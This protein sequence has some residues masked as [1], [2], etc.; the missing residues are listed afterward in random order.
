M[1][2]CLFSTNFVTKC[3][4]HYNCDV[5]VNV[6]KVVE[7]MHKFNK[8]I[9]FSKSVVFSGIKKFL[10]RSLRDKNAEIYLT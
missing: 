5:S 3:V 8:S 7:K 2:F 4:I 1:Q 10:T 6:V 9:F